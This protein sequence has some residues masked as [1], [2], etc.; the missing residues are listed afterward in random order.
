VS[1]FRISGSR[2]GSLWLAVAVAAT[3]A[4]PARA[5]FLADEAPRT[6][7]LLRW[8]TDSDR[9]SVRSLSGHWSS[10]IRTTAGLNIDVNNERVVIP[11][12][13]APPGTQEAVDAITTASRP[14]SGNAFQDFVKVRNEIQGDYERGSMAVSYYVSSESDYLGQQVGGRWSRDLKADARNLSVGGSFGWD[15]IAPVADDDTNTGTSSK[16]TLHWNAVFTDV[17]SPT[18]M[19]RYGVEWNLV[20]GLQHNPYRNV[21]AGGTNVPERHPENRQRRDAFVRVTHALPNRSSVKLSYRFYNDDWGVDSHEVDSRLSQ[22]LTRGLSV[23]WEYRW[24]TQTPAEFYRDDYTDPTGVDGYRTGD[25]RLGD[26]ASHLFGGALRMDLD[27]LAPS[28]TVFRR[29]SLWFDVERY[30][31]SN[32]YSAN[33]VETGV[34]FRFP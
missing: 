18:T 14:I 6:G 28:H 3:W 7:A 20:S 29:L 19:L 1:V 16:K 8:F 27:A 10:P 11:A 9:V 33:V 31:N 32:H 12:I 23:R 15:A 24:Y 26:L 25:Y 13:T 30:F 4:A 17:L 2:I 34:D 21:Y 5:Q 22:Y